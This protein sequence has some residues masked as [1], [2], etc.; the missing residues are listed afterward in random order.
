[1]CLFA[2]E[3]PNANLQSIKSLNPVVAVYVYGKTKTK[4]FLQRMQKK[5]RFKKKF[6]KDLIEYSV[7]NSYLVSRV[8]VCVFSN[9]NVSDIL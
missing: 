1:M 7:H 9:K 6:K 8:W 2:V 5:K 3:A 4:Q